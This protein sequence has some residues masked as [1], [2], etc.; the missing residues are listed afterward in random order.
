MR[1][2]VDFLNFCTILYI[3][4]FVIPLAHPTMCGRSHGGVILR[5]RFSYIHNIR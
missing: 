5:L 2:N 1:K 4:M 3:G